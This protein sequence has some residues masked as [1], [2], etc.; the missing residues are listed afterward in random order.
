MAAY[1]TGHYLF[2]V[3]NQGFGESSEKKTP[4]FFLEGMPVAQLEQ[5]ER[6]DIE[7]TS[8]PRTIKLYITEKTSEMVAE[9]LRLVGWPGGR[10]SSLNLDNKDAYSFADQEIEAVCSHEPGLKND[11]KMYDKWD[12]P[13]PAGS[14]GR[15]QSDPSIASRL[16]A[17]YGRTAAPKKLAKASNGA[18]AAVATNGGDDIPF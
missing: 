9:K 3:T 6:L 5:G 15:L 1:E 8:Y 13:M 7:G 2:R 14:G 16:D 17:L 11:G 18:K 10:W 12:L 4:F